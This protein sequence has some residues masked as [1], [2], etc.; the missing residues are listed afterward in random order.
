[1]GDLI[2]F[3][4]QKK[5]FLEMLKNW[6]CTPKK[7]VDEGVHD[8]SWYFQ[9][10]GKGKQRTCPTLMSR[11]FTDK[12][13]ST[14]YISTQG[15]ISLTSNPNKFA[16]RQNTHLAEVAAR[17]KARE[18]MLQIPSAAETPTNNTRRCLCF[19]SLDNQ[20]VWTDTPATDGRPGRPRQR[21]L[22][23]R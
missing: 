22:N 14:R 16:R 7:L 5:L 8:V 1:M 19:P 3:C 12:S 21:G 20:Q 15:T 10:S 13:M 2:R 9:M 6:Q 17:G 4:Q 18:R 23:R 11:F